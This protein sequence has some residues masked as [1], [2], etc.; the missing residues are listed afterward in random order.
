MIDLDTTGMELR[1]LPYDIESEQAV[2]GSILSDPD[3]ITEALELLR[4]QDFYSLAHQVIFQALG[5]LHSQR[6][7]ADHLTM[8]NQLRKNDALEVSGGLDYILN[9]CG[10]VPSDGALRH[11]A[12][13]VK[14]YATRRKLIELA[15]SL[16]AGAWDFNSDPEEIMASIAGN[17]SDYGVSGE[18]ALRLVGDL[19]PR[20]YDNLGTVKEDVQRLVWRTGLP[21]MDADWDMGI[22]SLVVVKA[23]R[24]SGKTHVMVDWSYRC[25]YHGRAAVIFSLEMPTNRMLQRVM[26][27]A[28]GVNSRV[29]AKPWNDADWASVAS[30]STNTLPLPIYI[31]GGRGTTTARMRT[32]LDSLKAKGV[33]VGMIGIDYAELIG[34]KSR[35]SREQELMGIATDLQSMADRSQATVVLLSQT[36]KEGAERYSEGIGN[37]ADLLLRWERSDDAGTLT[38]EKNR[39]SSSFRLPARLDCR[40]SELQELTADER[41]E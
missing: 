22:P 16:T 34:C 25:A 3:L 39:L 8:T 7:P 41:G 27:R 4:P 23:R 21:T 37:A 24:G 17:V 11:Y 18:D 40:I 28:G 9:L 14:T 30:A 5:E 38:A 32:L 26:A 35:N 33:D 29:I 13:M 36:N 2:L 6:I 31:S 19:I 12:E 20:Y 10:K 1:P 15:G